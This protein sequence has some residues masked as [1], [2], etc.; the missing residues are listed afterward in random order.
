MKLALTILL[1]AVSFATASPLNA[2]NPVGYWQGVLEVGSAELRI[3]VNIERQPEGE[4]TGAVD[5]PDQNAR[6][7]PIDD[8][9]AIDDRLSF[10]IPSIDASYTARWDPANAVWSGTFRQAGIELPMD[11]RAGQRPQARDET[12]LPRTWGFPPDAEIMRLLNERIGGRPGTGVVV[13]LVERDNARVI[14]IAP[15]VFPPFNGETIFEIGSM[16]KVFTALLLADMVLDGTVS[17]DDPVSRYL[18]E[19]AIVPTRNGRQITLRNLSQ[20]DSGLPRLPENL[21][22]ADIQN[23]YADYTEQNMLDFLAGYSLT[24]DVGGEYEYSNL[25]FGLL[26]FAL[27]RAEGTDFETL[28]RTRILEQLGMRNTV[29]A[30][31]DPQRAR[32][33]I[34]RDQ[35]NR[36]TSEWDLPA[37]AGAGALR[38]DATDIMVFLQ[39][40]LDPNSPIGP[41][42]QLTLA[43]QREAPGYSTGL[44]WMTVSAPEGAVVMHGGGTGGYR[45]HMALQP[46]TGRAVVVL[47]NSAVTPAA[48]DMAMH[49]LIGAPLAEVGPVPVAPQTVT[50]TQVALT[51]DQLDRVTGTYLLTPGVLMMI[52]RDGSQLFARISGQGALP[53]Y[54]RA[55]LEFFWRTVNAEIVFQEEGGQVKGAVFSQD[56]ARFDMEKIGQRGVSD[57]RN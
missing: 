10:K 12:P 33:A 15:N 44:G 53:I 5:S 31:A 21:T 3:G 22:P 30:L 32:F 34:G 13:G 11:L 54:P 56:G 4:L 18:P 36:P 24:R 43:D 27:A 26:G 57:E 7:I 29:I 23:P 16:T 42:M 40:A 37:L 8:I 35:Y 47:T 9:E 41:H 20:H 52:E 2:Q 14:A 45:T 49:I 39:A 48:Q 46:D 25:G 1:A 6:N 55:P 38:S 28:L 51:S 17:L 50:R 19:G